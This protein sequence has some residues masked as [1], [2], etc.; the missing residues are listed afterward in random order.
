MNGSITLLLLV[1]TPNNKMWTGCLVFVNI[2][3]SFRDRARQWLFCEFTIW[4]WHKFISSE[5]NQNMFGQRVCLSLLKSFTARS[6]LLF[7]MACDKKWSFFILYEKYGMFSCTTC[8][9]RNS[10]TPMILAMDLIDLLRSWSMRD[11]ISAKKFENSFLI[12]TNRVR[13]LSCC[14]FV[15]TVEFIHLF[16][17]SFLYP[18]IGTKTLKSFILRLQSS[19][20]RTAWHFQIEWIWCCI[21]HRQCPTDPN[22]LHSRQNS[23]QTK[24]MRKISN[25]RTIYPLHPVYISR[26]RLG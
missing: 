17:N 6:S 16:P 14:T 18:Q 7:F 4:F 22:L 24:C 20:P 23:K 5:K 15:I 25:L 12:G 3:T 8:L 11:W 13:L 26:W 1:K 10:D 9:I 21:P 2:G 19:I